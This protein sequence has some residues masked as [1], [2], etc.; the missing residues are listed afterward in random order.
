M[1]LSPGEIAVPCGTLFA[2]MSA[3]D[4]DGSTEVT[5]TLPM[6]LRAAFDEKFSVIHNPVLVAQAENDKVP[7]RIDGQHSP[8]KSIPHLLLHAVFLFLLQRGQLEACRVEI[9]LQFGNQGL[10]FGDLSL[11]I[12]SPFGR[13]GRTGRALLLEFLSFRLQICRQLADL[14]FQGGPVVGQ[15]C[16]LRF[17]LFQIGLHSR[18]PR[19]ELILFRNRA[20]QILGCCLEIPL[21]FGQLGLRLANGRLRIRSPLLHLSELHLIQIPQALRIRRSGESQG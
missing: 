7:R 9:T 19:R 16:H 3:I 13:A 6:I 20:R 14:R 1:T 15:L 10:L 12:C 8:G 4:V 2:T 18:E 21:R 17:R 11:L 5:R